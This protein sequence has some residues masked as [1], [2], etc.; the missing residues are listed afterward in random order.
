MDLCVVGAGAAGLAA[1]RAAAEA[2]AEVL[3]LERGSRP[4]LKILIS[5]GGRCN[6]TTALPLKE[7]ERVFSPEER[8]FLRHALRACPPQRI[9]NWVEEAGVPTYVEDF[10]KVFPRSDR[11]EDVRRVLVQAALEAGVELRCGQRVLG[12]SPN[13]RG[14]G[15]GGFELRL[16]G[17]GALRCKRLILAT[18]GLSYPKTGSSGDGF[19]WLREMGVPLRPLL[20]AL[21]PLVSPAG[22]LHSL[23]GT[24]LPDAECQLRTS[25]GRIVARRRR[26]LLFTHFGISGPGPMDLSGALLRSRE[27]KGE[28]LGF[29]VDLCPEADLEALREHC[30]EGRGGL[31]GRLRA[32]GIPRRVAATLLETLELGQASPAELPRAKR[33]R[34]LSTLKGWELP[35]SGSQGFGRAETTSGGV[36]LSEMAP[37][38][39][40]LKR[41]PGLHLSG[42]LLDVDAPIGGFSFWLAFA[43]GALAGRAA[44]QSLGSSL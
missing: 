40:E 43:T 25:G 28:P 36:P 21:V 10:D 31:Q 34:L 29:F 42:E 15:A 32:L 16:E 23:T 38:T 14:S 26:P 9:R 8:R 2:G 44:A 1:A 22:W 13:S 6:L 20:P 33:N 41:V 5:G 27:E 18:G 11:A 4:G 30:F 19:G 37:R 7:A 12:L 39:L 3:L 24:T 17:G 35:I